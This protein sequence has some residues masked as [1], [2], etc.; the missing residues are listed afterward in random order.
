MKK[1]HFKQG[2]FNVTGLCLAIIG[3][4]L[5]MLCLVGC[6]TP[7][8]RGL[9]FAKVTDAQ[10][11]ADGNSVSVYYGWQGYCIEDVKLECYS[12]RSIMIVPFD[13]AIVSQLNSTYPRLFTDEIQQ[14]ADLNPGA[15]PN[16]SHDPKIFPAAVLCLLCSSA[17]LVFCFYRVLT[18]HKYQDEHYTRGF[19][20]SGSAILALLLTI[21]SNVMYQDAVEQLN[22]TYPH[23]IASTGPCMPMIGCSFAAFFLA[24]YFLLRGCM[25]MESSSTD[26]YNPI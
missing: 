3:F 24:S 26:G 11:P 5:V 12:D 10:T 1:F 15:A 17:C 16:P 9:Y 4:V 25:S 8:G 23:L 14:D 21:L 19:L 22:M 7:S 20:A 18:P 2:P 6:Q 13:T